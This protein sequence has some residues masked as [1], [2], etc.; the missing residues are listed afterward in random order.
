[1]FHVSSL[2]P[3]QDPGQLVHCGEGCAF[4]PHG[5]KKTGRKEGKKTRHS[6]LDESLPLVNTYK[7]LQVSF[8]S[9]LFPDTDCC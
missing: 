9:E 2:K 6:Q 4:D 3:A 1:M 7:A 5:L 8:K